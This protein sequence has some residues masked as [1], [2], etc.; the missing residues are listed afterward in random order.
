MG[1]LT[2]TCLSF[3]RLIKSPQAK[4]KKSF[5]SYRQLD[6]KTENTFLS[7]LRALLLV[8]VSRTLWSL[9]GATGAPVMVEIA[10]SRKKIV[11]VS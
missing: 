9:A 7:R 4:C 1:P 8:R 3:A 6:T 11:S 10:V 2:R 5:S